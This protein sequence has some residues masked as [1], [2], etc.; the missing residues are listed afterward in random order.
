MDFGTVC[1][2]ISPTSFILWE[3]GMLLGFYLF[4]SWWQPTLF[5][6]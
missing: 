5:G 4:T 6:S 3:W 1:L 2:S